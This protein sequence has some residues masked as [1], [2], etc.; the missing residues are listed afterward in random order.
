[1]RFLAAVALAAAANLLVG[2]AV[3]TPPLAT[4]GAHPSNEPAPTAA[5]ASA[6]NTALPAPSAPAA[7]GS[8]VVQAALATAPLGQASDGSSYPGPYFLGRAEAPVVLE[9]Y[10]DFQ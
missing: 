8:A 2:C 3:Q 5:P 9:E 1:L 7:V 4:E 10:A 6:A